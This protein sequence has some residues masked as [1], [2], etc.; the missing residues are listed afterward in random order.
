MQTLK[1]LH[2]SAVRASFLSAFSLV[3]GCA[4]EALFD[5]DAPAEL[6]QIDETQQSVVGGT[7]ATDCQW[8]S[9]VRVDPAQCTGTLI[10]PRIVTTAAHCMT[11]T[12]ASIGF[13]TRGAPG[14]FSVSA[15]CVAGA[16]G[17]SGGN[18]GRDWAYCVLPEDPRIAK[19]TPTPPLVGCEAMLVKP[20]SSAWVVGYGSTTARGRAGVKRQVE[21]KINQFNKLAPGT[22]DVGDRYA[23]ACHGDSGGPLYVRLVRDGV[24]YGLRTMGSTS[25]AGGQCDC[26]CSTTYVNIDNHIKAIEKNEG[27]D[28]TPCTDAAG[29]WDPTPAC[30]GFESA[31]QSGT[32]TFPEC[33]VAHTT[34]PIESCGQAVT[35]DAD[36]G[37]KA[38]AGLDKDGGVDAGAGPDAGARS[39][40]GAPR[41]AATASDAAPTRDAGS[42]ATEQRRDAA[43]RDSSLE[44]EAEEEEEE[45]EQEEED[46][47]G[48][49]EDEEDNADYAAAD[50]GCSASRTRSG[51]DALGLALVALAWTCRRQRRRR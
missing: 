47:E 26:T 36:A 33:T 23:G 30:S 49:E 50:S 27:I 39:D 38:D 32:G 51:L 41:D 45:E 24:D 12:T 7:T 20:G 13:G 8:P 11:G 34:S 6:A 16:R 14:S 31:P 29:K 25:G 2:R 42:Q 28:V 9:T 40:G 44:E 43:A 1:S 48:E 5:A 18:T 10:H 35:T 46:E 37:T 19:I 22:I 17:S 3:A 21:V 4:A 15:R